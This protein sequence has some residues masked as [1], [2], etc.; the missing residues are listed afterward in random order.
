MGHSHQKGWRELFQDVLSKSSPKRLIDRVD[1]AESAIQRRL[2]DLAIDWQQTKEWNELN[3]A[4]YFL[5]LL[6]IIRTDGRAIA[7][8]RRRI[9]PS[10]PS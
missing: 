5:R 6:R 4:L 8:R 1:E 9:T 7:E 3:V 2:L 10:A